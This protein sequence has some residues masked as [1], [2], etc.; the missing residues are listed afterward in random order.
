MANKKL[1]LLGGG[2]HCKSVLDSVLRS[3]EFSKIVITDP[4][5]EK[6]TL[7][8]GCPVVGTDDVLSM[9][10]SEGFDYAFITVGSIGDSRIR[11]KLVRK[12]ED[13][14][15]NFPVIIDP[16]AEIAESASIGAGTFVGKNT[17]VNADCDIGCHCIINT[18]AVL[19]HECTVGDFSHV[20]VGAI[21]CGGCRVG[22]DSFVGAGSVVIQGITIGNDTVI[23]AS[24]TVLTN[25]G[26]HMKVC[27]F[28]TRKSVCEVTAEK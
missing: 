27:K 4:E 16:S 8:L 20:S 19:E 24:S 1:V 18:S 3:G 9:L 17:V 7:I 25:L 28:V 2:G 22:F 14:G 11:M 13:I 5:I 21:L 6:G 10:K 15:F 26:D 23:G 12:A